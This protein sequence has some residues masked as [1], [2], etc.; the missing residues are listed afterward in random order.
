V[1][2]ISKAAEGHWRELL[3]QLGVDSRYL[4]NKHGPCPIC[5]GKDRFR[6]DDQG[7]GGGFICG[8]CG[9]GDGFDLAVKVTGQTFREIAVQVSA[10]LG[11]ARSYNAPTVATDETR[12]RDAFKRVWMGSTVPSDD[13]PVGVYLKT[14]VGCV[15]PSKS[16]RQSKAS[17][18]YPMMVCPIVAHDGKR[19][20]NLHLTFLTLDG[21]KA[22]IS[23]AKK[24]MPGRLPDGC[25]IRLA[26]AAACMGVAEGIE[27]AISAAIMYDIPVWSCVN[28][29]LLSKWIPPA[30]AEEIAIF[31][32]NDANYTGQAKAY[33]LA[34][35][36]EVQH[37][38]KAKVYFPSDIDTD[39][40][41]LHQK[42]A[43]INRGDFEWRINSAILTPTFAEK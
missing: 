37:K 30:I 11:I 4:I 39:F 21:N 19:V 17:N 42:I 38:I 40:N 3:P 7:G 28:G 1:S 29:T 20:E 15:W 14:R 26:P 2:D 8:Q 6:W 13:G 24:V 43:K 36:L 35:R 25:A 18:G 10:I 23:P 12:Q 41:D 16:I 9:G 32:D 31:G 5:D 33:H 22:G 27:N 34:N